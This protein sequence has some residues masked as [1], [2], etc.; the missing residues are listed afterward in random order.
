[1]D[2]KNLRLPGLI[3]L[4]PRRFSD[5][6]GYFTETYNE[7]VFAAAGITTKFVQDNQSLSVFK[8]TVR[9][10]HFQLPPAA[11]A[12]LVRVL[13]GSVYDVAIDLRVGSPTYGQTDAATLT[14]D[15]GE[16]IFVP[17]GFAHGFCT[18]EPDTVV[19]YKV[20]E[21]YAPASDSGLIWNDPTLAIDWPVPA[22]EAVLSDKDKVL[23]RFADFKS[24][25]KYEGA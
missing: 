23:G 14:A 19:A 25:F 1:M 5:P 15:G 13:Q 16:Q 2:V 17:H 20:D 4:K 7:K 22:A 21:F 11:Q 12:K 18:L 9:G 6:R 3:V 8:G 10:L 24:P